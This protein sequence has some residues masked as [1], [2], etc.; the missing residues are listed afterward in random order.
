VIDFQS[1]VLDPSRLILKK[2]ESEI[3]LTRIETRLL[4]LLGLHFRQ[5]VNHRQVRRIVWN[6]AHGEATMRCDKVDAAVARIR[7]KLK[8]HTVPLTIHTSRRFGF[9]LDSEMST[10][11]SSRLTALSPDETVSS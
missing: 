6:E 3:E 5:W 1:C 8:R 10:H 9:M 4:T 11:R 7:R 2:G